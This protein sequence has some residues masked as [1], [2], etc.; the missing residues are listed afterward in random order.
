MNRKRKKEEFVQNDDSR[1]QNCERGFLCRFFE[2]LRF[3]NF[4][5]SFF[6]GRR[7]ELKL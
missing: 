4:S 2:A 5:R 1:K 6:F 7:T 3:Q